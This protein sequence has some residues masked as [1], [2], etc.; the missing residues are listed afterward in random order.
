MS[1]NNTAYTLTAIIRDKKGRILSIGKNSY[2]KTHPIMLRL[3]E[4][5]GYTKGEKVNLHAE[6]DAIN[7]CQNLGKAYSIE[8]FNY[9]ERS[10]TY[11]QSRPC[12]ICMLGISK[13]P[14]KIIKYMNKNL[15]SVTEKI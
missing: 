6:I 11:K 7:K 13:T 1:N 14:I 4:K 9:S 10:K 15:E 12:S 2:I 3:A 8:V 5:V